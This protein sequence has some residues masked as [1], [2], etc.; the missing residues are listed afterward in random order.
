MEQLLLIVYIGI[1][2]SLHLYLLMLIAERLMAKR[3]RR[4]T[5]NEFAVEVSKVESGG[6]DDKKQMSIAQIKRVLHIADDLLGGDLY[7]C[8]KGT[9]AV[10]T[11]SCCQSEG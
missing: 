9:D 5:L 4:Q 3:A 8:V 7:L 11:G 10:T 1:S 2:V 6:K